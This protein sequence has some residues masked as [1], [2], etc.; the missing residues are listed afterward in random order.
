MALQELPE[1]PGLDVAI[2]GLL[3]IPLI[4][5]YDGT[6]LNIIGPYVSGY[7]PGKVQIGQSTQ[8]SVNYKSEIVT[9]GASASGQLVKNNAG[10]GNFA[11]AFWNAG[12]SG[13][14]AFVDFATEG[15]YTQRGFIDYTRS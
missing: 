15:T 9:S 12:T 1:L 13:D 5:Q 4:V 3:G 8:T 6:Q 2:P 10:A 11:G 14:N 7:I